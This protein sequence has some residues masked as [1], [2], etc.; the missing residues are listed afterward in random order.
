MSNMHY[1]IEK[2]INMPNAKK[3]TEY[4]KL[5]CTYLTMVPLN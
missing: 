2:R 1:K 3:T 4:A 5:N